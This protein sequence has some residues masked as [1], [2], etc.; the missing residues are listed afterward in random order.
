MVLVGLVVGAAVVAVAVA[1]PWLPEGASD[2]SDAVDLTYWIVTGICIAVFAL[3][4]AVS[5]YAVWKFRAP[6]DDL[7]DGKPIHGN[8]KLEIVWTLIP[9]I[10]V[11]VISGISGWALLDIQTVAQGTRI[12]NV[13]AQQFAWSFAYPNA[14]DVT[15]GELVLEQGEPVELRLTA[16]DVIHSFWVPEFRMKQDAVPGIVTS[17]KVTP[18]RPGSY[19][20]ICTEL[21]GLGHSV[22]RA[23]AVVLSAEDYAAWLQEQEGGQAGGGEPGGSGGGGADGMALFEQFGCGG[24]H[25]LAE[26][27]SSAQVGPDLDNVLAGKDAEYVRTAIVEPNSEITEGFQP[28]VMPQDF[29]ERIPS[30][31]LDALVDYLL[32]ATEAG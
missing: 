15:S 7:E 28:G 20:V 24:C 9:T 26:A 12:V 29:G 17:V 23:R 21:C 4:A 22:M 32:T 3:V 30:E 16:K 10:L 14:N 27:G 31:Q 13:T 5:I 25:T 1:I 19:E 6:P 11:T 8:T 2:E 18:K